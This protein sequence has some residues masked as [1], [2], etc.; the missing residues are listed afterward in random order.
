MVVDYV[1]EFGVNAEK[2]AKHL[3]TLAVDKGSQ[4]NVTVIVVFFEDGPL[5]TSCKSSL[6]RKLVSCVTCQGRASCSSK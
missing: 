1:K 5:V 4:D 2:A 6:I 3:V